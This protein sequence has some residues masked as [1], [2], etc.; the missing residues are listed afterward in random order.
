MKELR[1]QV[2]DDNGDRWSFP[3]KPYEWVLWLLMKLEL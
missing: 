1:I 3:I 2:T